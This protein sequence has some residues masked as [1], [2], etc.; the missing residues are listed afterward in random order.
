MDKII[1]TLI[2][3]MFFAGCRDHLAPQHAEIEWVGGSTLSTIDYYVWGEQIAAGSS[4][5]GLFL[6]KLEAL[7]D[8]CRLNFTYPQAFIEPNYEKSGGLDPLPFYDAGSRR[9][10][11]DLCLKKSFSTTM[12][13]KK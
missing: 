10:F 7:P 13:P 5:Y 12:K 6:N 1:A 11:E 8:R 4:A 9:L 3:L 2:I